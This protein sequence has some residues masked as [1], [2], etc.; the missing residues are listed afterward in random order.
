MVRNDVEKTKKKKGIR[1]YQK[2]SLVKGQWLK[3]WEAS[4]NDYLAKLDASKNLRLLVTDKAIKESI[5]VESHTETEIWK[6]LILLEC[7]S[8]SPYYPLGGTQEERDESGKLYAGQKF[9]KEGRKEIL[10]RI[11]NLLGIDVSYIGKFEK[12]LKSA[13]RKI[14]GSAL[15]ITLGITIGILAVLAAIFLTGGFGAIAAAFAP[16]GLSGAAAISS[17]LAALGGGAVA[18]G[19][20]GV[21]GGMAVIVGGGS[22]IGIGL[23]GSAG[24]V[25]AKANSKMVMYEAVK[26][27]VVMK[28]ILLA[29]Q[30]DTKSFQEILNKLTADR[31][32]L[33]IEVERLKASQEESKK[34]IKELEKSI[35]YLSRLIEDLRK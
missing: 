19:G 12:S 22:L 20:F 30:K 6:Y 2:Q 8:F 16:E 27:E 13:L 17:G 14:S 35:K 21:A 11:A 9:D 5:Q 1:D 24:L 25:I 32:E 26:L 15:I 31:E 28:E 34:Q 7:V 4:I 10:V 29:V 3:S 33:R 23:G 18:A